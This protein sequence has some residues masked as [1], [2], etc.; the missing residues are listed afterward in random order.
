MYKIFI[1][2]C[3]SSGSSCTCTY[4]TEKLV[5]VVMVARVVAVVARKCE[6]WFFWV[7][8]H[9][10]EIDVLYCQCSFQAALYYSAGSYICFILLDVACHLAACLG[11]WDGE[12]MGCCWAVLV[13]HKEQQQRW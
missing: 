7:G 9:G 13:V 12:A 11:R 6:T 2:A 10:G 8:G 1:I 3:S 4:I 5:A